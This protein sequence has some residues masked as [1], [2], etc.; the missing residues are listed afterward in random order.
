MCQEKLIY[1]TMINYE[2]CYV[3]WSY[4]YSTKS[5]QVVQNVI[6]HTGNIL[7][8]VNKSH[9][10]RS[11]YVFINLHI[12]LQFYRCVTRRVA[13]TCVALLIDIKIS[14]SYGR[15]VEHIC[16]EYEK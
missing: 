15:K 10:I 4:F 9:Q 6:D 12:K 1:K 16:T 5:V 2:C 7:V 13:T 8:G 3:E 11:Y 14:I